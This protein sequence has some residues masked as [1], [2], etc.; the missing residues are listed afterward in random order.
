[1]ATAVIIALIFEWIENSIVNEVQM[2]VTTIFYF[3][4]VY[5]SSQPIAHL[6]GAPI[7]ELVVGPVSCCGG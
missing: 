6:S 2:Q 3:F 1:M 7:K 4:P 5:L